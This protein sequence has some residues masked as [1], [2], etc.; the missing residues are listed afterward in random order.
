MVAATSQPP[1]A[2]H[3]DASRR[4]V[5]DASFLSPSE[6]AGYTDSAAA[7]LLPH[8]L[9]DDGEIILLLIRPSVLFIILSC[10][11]SL[12]VIAILTLT[13]ALMANKFAGVPWSDT[14]ALALGCAAA[15]LRVGWQ[16]LEW[17]SRV[18]VLTDRR[19]IRRSGVLR[20]SVFEAPLRNIQHTSVFARLRERFFGL[21]TLAFAT[22]GTD[23]F[24][25]FWVMIYNPFHVQHAVTEAIRKYRR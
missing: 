22:A 14:Q 10:I 4:D 19:V 18:Y 9:I 7:S 24:N 1:P 17:L 23:S 15:V 25:M 6:A 16:T 3:S 13:L 8:S 21:G 11:G 20:V 5:L 2:P 12:M